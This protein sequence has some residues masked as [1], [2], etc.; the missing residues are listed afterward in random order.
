VVGLLVPNVINIAA[1][2]AAMGE[3][4]RAGGGGPAHWYA[5]GFGVLSPAA[6]GVPALQPLRA[7]LKWLTL[8]LLAYVATALV[9]QAA[10]EP[11]AAR[12]VLPQLN[13]TRSYITTV[14]AVFG[15]T[16]SP[17]LFFWQ[18]SQEVEELRADDAGAP[19]RARRDQAGEPSAAHQGRHLGRHGRSRTWSPSSS[20]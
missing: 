12:T 6:A 13:G 11:G 2:I 3:A 16:I 19:L 20:C 8:A 5:L 4:M 7:L 17:Y 14:V 10:V 9:V 15:T 18:A 1:D